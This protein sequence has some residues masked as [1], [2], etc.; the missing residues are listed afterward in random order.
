MDMVEQGRQAVGRINPAV[1]R[2]TRPGDMVKAK[3]DN[4]RWVVFT[5][6]AIKRGQRGYAVSLRTEGGYEWVVPRVRWTR[7]NS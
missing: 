6:T 3:A 5:V 4:G 7:P 1:L 2:T